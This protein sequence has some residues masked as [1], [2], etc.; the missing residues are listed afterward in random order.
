MPVW[1]RRLYESY[2]Q[3]EGTERV[4]AGTVELI[5]DYLDSVQVR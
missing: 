2:P 5:L 4:K 1:G 3:T